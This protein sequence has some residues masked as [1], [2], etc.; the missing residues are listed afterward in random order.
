MKGCE[1]NGKK[2]ERTRWRSRK[3]LEFAGSHINEVSVSRRLT[4]A[5]NDFSTAKR[6]INNA[7]VTSL[8][9]SMSH[10]CRCEI[11]TSFAV[12]SLPLSN[13]N[14]LCCH[15]ISQWVRV[16]TRSVGFKS[17]FVIRVLDRTFC[18]LNMGKENG[19]SITVEGFSVVSDAKWKPEQD[20]PRKTWTLTTV[21]I[22]LVFLVAAGALAV[23]I[24]ALYKANDNNSTTVL[25][26]STT[27]YIE[28]STFKTNNFG[29]KH[30]TSKIA[31]GS[32]T[33]YYLYP[34]TIWTT[35]KQYK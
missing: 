25:D 20:L 21:L 22:F 10:H 12:T 23:A 7:P 16:Y 2:N 8:H 18:F 11:E 34:Q 9:Y 3:W 17:R 28:Q 15:I 35:V 5:A 6:H 19:N 30:I 32:C 13:R 1:R 31:F 26:S 29:S 33:T 27:G 14:V 4:T 24:V